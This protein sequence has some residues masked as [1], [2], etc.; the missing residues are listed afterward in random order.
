MIDLEET[1]ETGSA[2]PFYRPP[3]D[4][5]ATRVRLTP[6]RRGMDA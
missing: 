5:P 3:A 4:I 6:V 1:R 2:P